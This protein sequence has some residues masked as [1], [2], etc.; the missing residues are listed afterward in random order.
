MTQLYSLQV[1]QMYAYL[2][3]KNTTAITTIE[4]LTK[5]TLSFLKLVLGLNY[6]NR[7]LWKFN[8]DEALKGFERLVEGKDILHSKMVS[9]VLLL[10]TWP[11]LFELQR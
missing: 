8:E 10:S 2:T 11:I 7:E 6:D 9:S 3:H 4:Y 5:T 1:S